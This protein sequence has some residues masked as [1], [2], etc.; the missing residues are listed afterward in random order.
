MKLMLTLLTSNDLHGLK[1]LVCNVKY[2]LINNGFFDLYPI[3]VVNTLSEEYYQEVLNQKFPFPVVRTESNGKPGKGKNSCF[4]IFLDSNCDY[5]TQFDG[6]DILYPTYLL[7]LEQHIRQYSCIDV[8]GIIPMDVIDYRNVYGYRF[9]LEENIYAGVWGVSLTKIDRELG[10]GRHESLWDH[11]TP[12]SVDFI[13]LQSKK[14][15]SFN[16]DENLAVGE[17]HLWSLEAFSKHVKGELAYFHTY[18]SD[19]FVIDRTNENSIQKQFPQEEHVEELRKKAKT[20]VTEYRSNLGELP[21]VYKEL[22]LDQYRKEEWL[23][24]FWMRTK[25]L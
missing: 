16:I 11:P 18:S 13:I 4:N 17:D 23:K 5:L 10:I 9:S 6:D 21:I 7:S 19:M 14:G 12:A 22:L 3:I 24:N 15:A 2:E 20:Y 25:N 1:R 8:L